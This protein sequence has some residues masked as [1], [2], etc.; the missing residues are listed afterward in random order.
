VL[1][2]T[3]TPAGGTTGGSWLLPCLFTL[4]GWGVSFVMFKHAY[5]LP[6]A[7]DFLFFLTNWV[8]IAVVLLP[9]G[10]HEPQHWQAAGIPLATLVVSLFALGDLTLFAAINRGPAAIVSPL[11]GLYPVPTLFYSALVL[12]ESILP[13]QWAAIAV[14]LFAIVLVVPEADNPLTQRTRA[15]RS[16]LRLAPKDPS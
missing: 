10:L 11:S 9:F 6:G 16:S 15:R 8:G 5:S 14:I 1:G 2:Y 13:V 12:H 4:T 7:D 3:G